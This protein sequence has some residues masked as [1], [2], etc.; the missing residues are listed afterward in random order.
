MAPEVLAGENPTFASD[1]WAVGIVLYEFLYGVTPFNI[2]ESN[3][4]ESIFRKICSE[5]PAFPED[6]DISA[7]ARDLIK[8]FLIKD[9]KK[10][11]TNI[12]NIV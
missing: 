11:L 3:D 4:E 7:D 12:E 10:R 1:F 8:Q 2:D 5:E 6:D 9:K